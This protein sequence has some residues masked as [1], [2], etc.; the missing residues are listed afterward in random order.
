MDIFWR[1]NFFSVAVP[2]AAPNFEILISQ[3]IKLRFFFKI[4]NHIVLFSVKKCYQWW[5]LLFF[6]PHLRVCILILEREE[7]GE[8]KREREREGERE[9][10]MW[11]KHRSVACCTCPGPGSNPPPFRVQDDAPTTWSTWPGRWWHLFS[12]SKNSLFFLTKYNKTKIILKHFAFMLSF[13]CFLFC[14]LHDDY[15]VLVPWYISI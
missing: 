5:H 3:N 12:E 2:K 1:S 4:M 15:H 7:G 11:A 9:T 10:S 13:Q 6:Y 14:M 8:K